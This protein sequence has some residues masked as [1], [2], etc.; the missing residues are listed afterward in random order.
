MWW[1]DS[2]YVE[3]SLFWGEN[4]KNI[5][6][7]I[8][9]YIVWYVGIISQLTSINIW[10]SFKLKYKHLRWLVWWHSLNT[11][12]A[13]VRKPVTFFGRTEK[14]PKLLFAY[15]DIRMVFRTDGRMDKTNIFIHVYMSVDTF[16]QYRPSQSFFFQILRCHIHTISYNNNYDHLFEKM[17]KYYL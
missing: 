8:F 15:S 5:N 7:K 14:C 1:I 3:C 17:N 6:K 11:K 2:I 16:T 4:K 12:S 9:S 13:N 10:K